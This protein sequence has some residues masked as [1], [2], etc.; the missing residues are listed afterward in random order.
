MNLGNGCVGQA[1]ATGTPL[2]S[3]DSQL[4]HEE[5]D[6]C[7]QVGGSSAAS[8]PSTE[9]KHQIRPHFVQFPR[10]LSRNTLAAAQRRR[11]WPC[12][13]T[14]GRPARPSKRWFSQRHAPPF[15][16]TILSRTDWAQENMPAGTARTRH[17]LENFDPP[18]W[19]GKEDARAIRTGY[20]LHPHFVYLYKPTIGLEKALDPWY[21]IAAGITLPARKCSSDYAGARFRYFFNTRSGRVVPCTCTRPAFVAVACASSYTFSRATMGQDPGGT[22]SAAQASEP[23]SSSTAAVTEPC[24]CPELTP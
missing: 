15:G 23:F 8:I 5:A 17:K 4:P 13:R 18:F 22:G 11:E 1:L 21:S 16:A 14:L 12:P 10:A 20:A 2:V 19:S 7:P 3:G 9:P 6:P 24:G